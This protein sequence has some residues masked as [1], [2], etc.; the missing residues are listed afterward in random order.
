MPGKAPRRKGDS[1]ERELARLLGGRRIPLSGAAGGVFAGDVEVPG[2]GRGEV[3][4]RRDGFKELYKWLENRDFLA[5]RADRKGW[6]IVMGLDEARDL[7]LHE[8]LYY[9]VRE[10]YNCIAD[11]EYREPDE[12]IDQALAILANMPG[13]DGLVPVELDA[14]CRAMHRRGRASELEKIPWLKVEKEGCS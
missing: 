11:P 7:L 4:R 12:R 14:F 13:P 9:A 2:L 1:G 6:L 5:L 10:D 8:C 3:K